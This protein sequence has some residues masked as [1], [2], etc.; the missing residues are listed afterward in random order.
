MTSKR[1]DS[2]YDGVVQ[3]LTMHVADAM[4]FEFEI[5]ARVVAKAL[6]AFE[7]LKGLAEPRELESGEWVLVYLVD[8]TEFFVNDPTK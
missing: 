8:E 3:R 4:T 6:L 5:D 7:M 2:R 1:L